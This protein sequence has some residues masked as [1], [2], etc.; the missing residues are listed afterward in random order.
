[1][2][3]IGIDTG[4][5]F[6]DFVRF[7]ADGLSVHKVRSTP[8]DPSR[9]I[10]QGLA[11]LGRAAGGLDVVHGSTVATN[12]VLERTGARVA[13]ITTAGF[14]DVVRIGRQTRRALYDLQQELPRPL[15]DPALTFGCRERL[16]AGGEVLIPLDDAEIA[17]VVGRV[18][19]SGATAAAVCFLH[20]YR[21]DAHERRLA[22]ALAA[23]GLAVS[24]SSAVLREY[25]EFERWSTTLVDAYVTPLMA[26]TWRRSRTAWPAIAWGSCS[27]TAGRSRRRPPGRPASAP[28][29]RGPPPAPSAPA[30]WPKRPATRGRSPSTWAGPP[31]TSA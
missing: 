16:A 23:A 2:I 15:V 9:A 13:L 3:R 25:R 11:D 8:D 20:A 12:A 4:G 24:A 6:T 31:A 27:P 7:D 26:P 28:S 14:E 21:N 10:L 29:C 18:R 19:A 5:T 22:E 17:A 30:P 1:M